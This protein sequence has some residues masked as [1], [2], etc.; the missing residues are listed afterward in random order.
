MF[1]N[2]NIL[3]DNFKFSPVLPN[4]KYANVPPETV[5]ESVQRVKILGETI[6]AQKSM[7][8]NPLGIPRAGFLPYI[9]LW[10]SYI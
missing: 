9:W 7:K 2:C 6:E 3:R 8:K 5:N 4:Y 10:L 1:K